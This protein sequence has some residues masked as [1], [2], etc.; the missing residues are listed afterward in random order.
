MRKESEEHFSRG[1]CT[2]RGDCKV[3]KETTSGPLLTRRTVVGTL[4]GAL[5]GAA[6]IGGDETQAAQTPPAAHAR[7]VWD[8][9]VVGAGVFGS[10]SAWNLRK[11]GKKVL[12]VDAWGPSH[13]RASSGGESRLTRTEYGGD[14]LFTRF[15]WES[16]PEWAALSKRAGLPVFHPIGALYLYQKEPP[17]LA[18][19]RV[20]NQKL[21][22]PM[23]T[24]ERAGLLQRYP[25][26]GL[27][28]IQFGVLQPTMGA[29]MARRSVQTLVNEF[30]AAGGTYRQ[31]AIQPPQPGAALD[32][33]T[34][35]SGETVRSKQFIFACGPWL[36]K[37]FP[38]AIG[39]RIVPT[40]QEV[41][42]FAPDPG[43]VRFEPGHLPAWVDADE[44]GIPYGFPAL[45]TR[46][47]KIAIDAHG[48]RI[49]PDVGDRII[50]QEGL[51]QV[52][53][54]L[55]RRFPALAQRP[56]AESRVCQYENSATGDFI[57]DRHPSWENVL[58]VGG[59]S[60]HGFKH[61]PAVGRYVADLVGGRLS[62]AEPRFALPA[63]KF[64]ADSS[65]VR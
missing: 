50:S 49:D 12:L 13:A 17:T 2:P 58:L 23:E 29:L 33:I 57:I 21:G 35:N 22:A 56:L 15:A 9:V 38:D 36:P 54:Y 63:H 32:A 27:D 42:F 51:R 61:G 53:G 60:G 43:D 62:K 16:L 34:S 19:S 59:G 48:P 46:G 20:L 44:P 37:M 24:I 8:A 4:A 47:F 45:E 5:A 39:T 6:A 14:E 40:R 28:G 10:W 18:A 30:V 41:F 11:Q 65:R 64:Q 3:K 7:Q 25:Q 55:A 26:L 1:T 31:L 52:R